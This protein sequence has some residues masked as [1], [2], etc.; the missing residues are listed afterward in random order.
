MSGSANN[1]GTTQV[2]F[3]ADTQSGDASLRSSSEEFAKLGTAA[4]TAAAKIE[5]AGKAADRT[6]ALQKKAADKWRAAWEREFYDQAR[7]E[8][9]QMDAAHAA[10]LLAL[11][12]D[13][14]M[15]SANNAADAEA[16]LAAAS[17]VAA[18]SG[19][20]L[21]TSL[22]LVDNAMRG[23]TSRGLADIIRGLSGVS[24]VMDLLPWAATA[25]GIYLLGKVALEGAEKI[26]GFGS[27]A[28]EARKKLQE[29]WKQVLGSVQGVNDE[30]TISN[31]RM[32]DSISELE[33]K[34]SDGLKT[35]LLEAA[36]AAKKLGDRLDEDLTKVQKLLLANKVSGLS[37]LAGDQ[38]GDI[39]RTI[40]FAVGQ[41]QRIAPDYEDVMQRAAKA[42]NWPNYMDARKDEIAA[43]HA[44]LDPQIHT[45]EDYLAKNQLLPGDKE[46]PA[47]SEA[48]QGYQL[49]M[50]IFSDLQSQALSEQQAH[51]KR[52]L[53]NT[54]AAE[55]AA[56]RS[57]SSPA[58]TDWKFLLQPETVAG[59]NPGLDY[60]HNAEQ[61]GAAP[62]AGVPMP[63]PSGRTGKEA[64][65]SYREET[66]RL[67]VAQVRAA[68]A[69]GTEAD[70]ID[71][72]TGALGLHAAALNA[73][74]RNAQDYK[75]QMKPL[76]EALSDLEASGMIL[77]GDAKTENLTEILRLQQ[78]MTEV[79]GRYDTQR[80]R[81]EEAIRT[82]TAMGTLHEKVIQMAD[83]FTNLGNILSEN[84]TA[85]LNSFNATL[86][87]V[88]STPASQLR[89]QHPWRNMGAGIAERAGTSALQYGE[90]TLMK[91]LTGKNPMAKLGTKD[92]PMYVRNADGG[93]SAG[94][95]SSGG[96]L[97]M[98]NS[99]DWAGKLF[100]GS[101]FGPGGIFD[102]GSGSGAAATDLG[103]G[104]DWLSGGE[105]LGIPAG[106]GGSIWGAG[107]AGFANGGRIESNLPVLVGEHGPE[108]LAGA[109]GRTVIPNHKIGGS[110]STTIYIDA[111]GA[112]DPAAT[113]AAAHRAMR[114]Y[115][116]M[117]KQ[118]TIAA[119]KDDARRRPASMQFR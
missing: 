15:R 99:S 87:K 42:G 94:G 77:T 62:L 41:Y 10:D 57:A 32:G 81:D 69:F 80:L 26:F 45:L 36:D 85:D 112:T 48:V 110:N 13:I 7:A 61:R 84:F 116:P 102:A 65:E 100:G 1:I 59:F 63:D 4:D 68:A 114:A 2:V 104:G 103:G 73:A 79:T 119:M 95:A 22:G 107:L 21:Q 106:L 20:R 96:I 17:D 38:R 30:L 90:G 44:A 25:A 66:D 6:A 82:T 75:L 47:H 52:T 34:P 83:D 78:Q 56:A 101:L 28:D 98:L 49:L 58:A 76:Q 39:S 64:V 3:E 88:L 91:L 89:G 93:K 33:K 9:A 37:E 18:G 70:R 72:A 31:S 27:A 14:L 24:A 40:G 92:N 109:G 115:Y 108:I 74:A 35:A 46:S 60:M 67:A 43:L 29:D 117:F 118:G 23:Q 16:E 54:R 105:S 12:N 111:R 8:R 97:G 86:M 71:V 11:K 5:G 55:R 51:E 113:E 53:E 19:M 50:G